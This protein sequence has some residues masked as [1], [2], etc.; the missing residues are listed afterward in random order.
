M[1]FR[2]LYVYVTC[3]LALV[4]PV[5]AQAEE[6]LPMGIFHMADGKYF[7]PSTGKTADMLQDFVIA[8]SSPTHEI[9]IIETGSISKPIKIIPTDNFPLKRAIRHGQDILR[10]KIAKEN[11]NT[12]KIIVGSEPKTRYITLAVWNPADD[13]IRLVSGMKN[14]IKFTAD[15]ATGEGIRVQQTNGINSQFSIKSTGEKVVAIQY[16]IYIDAG[17]TKKHKKFREE[18]VVYTPYSLAIHTTDMVA[19]GKHWLDA[20]IT[21]VLTGLRADNVPSRSQPS[22]LLADVVSPE[23]IELIAAIEHMDTAATN[24]D[25]AKQLERFYV[26]LAANEDDS[27]DYSRSKVGALGMVQFMPKTYAFVAKQSQL[28]LIQDFEVGMRTPINAIRAQ[29][30]YLDY[31]ATK[32]PKIDAQD[33]IDEYIA[34]AYNGGYAR[35]KKAISVWD[36]NLDIQDRKKIKSKSRLKLETMHYVEKLRLVRD[37]L[38]Q[39]I[40]LT[41][42]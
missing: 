5:I 2:F 40:D 38:R 33:S 10:G 4:V 18:Q 24:R 23:L 36:E 42:L 9:Q 12:K 20:Q 7:Q 27:Y 35:V 19:Y 8:E 11:K 34:A 13:K 22:K 31:L 14:G 1:R 37:Q 26:T 15:N 30:A 28:A 29:V 17:G 25:P 3:A 39:D 41:I 32:L 21:A 6:I 16:P